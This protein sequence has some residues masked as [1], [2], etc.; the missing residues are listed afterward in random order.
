MII[1]LDDCLKVQAQKVPN[2]EALVY[3][4]R[5][6]SYAE[7]DDEVDRVAAI[8]LNSGLEKNDRVAVFM[9]KSPE[10]A[11]TLLAA[12][13]AGGVFI[14]VNHLL[15]AHQVLHILRDSGTKFLFTTQQRLRVIASVIDECPKLETLIIHGPGKKTN[16]LNVNI[17]ERGEW[18]S[19]AAQPVAKK[20][21]ETDMGAI[22]YTSGST[23]NPKGVVL[24]HRNLVAGAESVSTYLENIPD[25]RILSV[26]PFSFD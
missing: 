10:E 17:V 25:D 2:K 26:L 3:K 5:R 11:V 6:I 9:E 21:V 1:T 4:D 16:N 14:D 12:N 15:K 8:L 18:G 7:F 19:E 22:I 13:R 20:I 24:T 23:G